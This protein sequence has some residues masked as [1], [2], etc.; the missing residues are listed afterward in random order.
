[1]AKL[2]SELKPIETD[3][4]NNRIKSAHFSPKI[5]FCNFF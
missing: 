1:M 3:R 2:L 5:D 4:W